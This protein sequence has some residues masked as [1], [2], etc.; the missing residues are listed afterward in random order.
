MKKIRSLS[1]AGWLMLSLIV[2]GLGCRSV[3]RGEPIQGVLDISDPKIARG[4]Q[5]FAR[6]CTMCHPGGEGGLGPALNN[7]P[8]PRWL[9]KTQVRLGLGVMPPFDKHALSPEDL[10]ALVNYSL[11]IRRHNPNPVK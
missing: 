7:S 4:Q 5:V 10:D 1:V 9:M 2:A 11:A 6:N 8:G 3:R